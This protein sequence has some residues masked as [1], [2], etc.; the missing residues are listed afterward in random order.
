MSCATARAGRRGSS[1]P[2][3]IEGG[4]DGTSGGAE[5]VSQCARRFDPDDVSLLLEPCQGL[6]ER[7]DCLLRL[8]GEPE[9]FDEAEPYLGLIVQLVRAVDLGDGLACE[10][11]GFVEPP[12]AR[13]DLRVDAAPERLCVVVVAG[14]GV[15]A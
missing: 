3:K 8:T 15:P 5:L 11:L 7:L 1:G 4:S 9:H 13:D 6:I 12:P 10:R 14:R 2:P